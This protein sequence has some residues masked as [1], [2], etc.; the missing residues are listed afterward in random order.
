MKEQILAVQKMQDYI[1]AHLEKEIRLSDL[2]QFSLFSPWY[3]Y[4]LFREQLGLSP[5]EYI[6]KLRLSRAAEALRERKG[7]VIDIAFDLGFSNVAVRTRM[8]RL[9]QTLK[10]RMEEYGYGI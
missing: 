7:K 10:H 8:M 2:A 5:A 4:R 3:S 9:R 6:R 1:G